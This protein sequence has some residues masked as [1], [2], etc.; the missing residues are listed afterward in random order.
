MRL[1]V[2]WLG[3]LVLVGSTVGGDV[4]MAAAPF[5][6]A[7]PEPATA[8]VTAC[9]TAA[10][11]P[12]WVCVN[13]GWVPADH[14]VALSAPASP[15]PSAPPP[16]PAAGCTT[17]D[18]FA[19]IPGLVG[20]CT[21]NNAWVP[22]PT[23][24]PPPSPPMVVPRVISVGDDV[25]FTL[26]LN[27]PWMYLELT[28]PSDGL[29]IVRVSTDSDALVVI[30]LGIDGTYYYDAAMLDVVAGQTYLIEVGI[31]NRWDYGLPPFVSFVM[32]SSIN[33][34]PVVSVP[35]CQTAPPAPD[36]VCV[37]AG[38]V[39][40]DHPLAL[41]APASPTPSSPPPAPATGCTTPDPFAGIPGLVGVCVGNGWVPLSHPLAG[42]GGQ[43]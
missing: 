36:W 39:P 11:A 26:D 18:P 33:S 22:Q 1:L 37:N 19:A 12:D 7:A 6:P 25:M 35:Q 32:T 23:T 30:Q 38:W 40:V 2:S 13:G 4:P 27:D 9:Q 42:G 41:S 15:T 5:A 29:L 28:A 10:P 43:F 31:A 3:V 20:V 14:P 21:G 34:G 16:A 8:D 24:A 17:P